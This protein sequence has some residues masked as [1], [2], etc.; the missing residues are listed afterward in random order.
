MDSTL[1]KVKKDSIR[2]QPGL[3]TRSGAKQLKDEIDKFVHENRQQGAEIHS[4]REVYLVLQATA[5]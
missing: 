1:E 3:M 2:D 4:N 5:D